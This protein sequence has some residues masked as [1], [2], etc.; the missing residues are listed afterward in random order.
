[1]FEIYCANC[2]RRDGWW[3]CVLPGQCHSW[4]PH[5]Q[6]HMD[7]CH[8]W[9]TGC[10]LQGWWRNTM[11]E[12]LLLWRALLLSAIESGGLWRACSLRSCGTNQELSA[13][14]VKGGIIVGLNNCVLQIFG[15][16]N[17]DCGLMIANDS[18]PNTFESTAI[19]LCLASHP[20]PPFVHAVH[21]G[22]SSPLWCPHS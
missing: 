1:M 12:L 15:F 17:I 20:V 19:S 3:S 8:W 18:L 22:V 14:T 10:C 21:R 6:A 13:Y 2:E 7:S 16:L 11:W 4:L 9:T 5:I